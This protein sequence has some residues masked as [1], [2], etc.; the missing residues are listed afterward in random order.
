MK[1]YQIDAFTDKIFGGNPA[2]VVPLESWLDGDLMQKIAEENNLSE[3][4]FFVKEGVYYHIRWF[5]PVFEVDLCGHATLA[6]AYVIH[7]HIDPALNPI[8]FTSRSGELI[9]D[10][11][12]DKFV[13]DF[14]CD[15]IHKTTAPSGLIEAL[16]VKS[17]DIWKGRDDYMVIIDSEEELAALN[18]DY[19]ALS[20]IPSRG[21]LVS[22]PSKNYDFVS[23]CFFPT[24]AINEDPVTGSA[25]TSL[26]PYWAKR[27]GK[28][29]MNACQISPRRGK[30]G[31][32]LSGDRVLL[33]GNAVQ[34]AVGQMQ[35]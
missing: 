26:T 19:G 8:R 32:K 10:V 17:D 35:L 14:P 21:I 34:Y 5:T 7:H 4:A 33:T 13:M 3:T 29:K 2:A 6:S 30:I 1:F 27:L 22:A 23:R 24:C 15:Q 31:C 25:H 12:E 28:M 9:V 18:P 20:K 16:G 11:N